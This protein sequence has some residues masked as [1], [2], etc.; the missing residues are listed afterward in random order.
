M[1]LL[2]SA[3]RSAKRF[4][5]TMTH[6]RVDPVERLLAAAVLAT[7]V[8][9]TSFATVRSAVVAPGLSA[10]LQSSVAANQ[11]DL[12]GWF[13]SA[14]CTQKCGHAMPSTDLGFAFGERP[15]GAMPYAVS[16]GLSGTF[17][18]AD[19]YV[20][21]RDA[22]SFPAGVGV[23]VAPPIQ[24][25]YEGQVYGRMDIPLSNRTRLLWNPGVFYHGGHSPNHQST[26]SFRAVVQSIGLQFDVGHVSITPSSSIVFGRA[27][28]TSYGQVYQPETRAFV[29]AAIGVTRRRQAASGR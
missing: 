13:W 22:A 5:P 11:G 24:G 28:R 19:A 29:T 4:V 26:G 17:P 16:L 8:G 6:R 14:D 25:W 10:N 3:F 2:V 1:S 15:R 18:Y 9:C 12:A 27:T 21:L 23:R 7:S 20:Q